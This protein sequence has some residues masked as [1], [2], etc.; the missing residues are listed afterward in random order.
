MY[1]ETPKISRAAAAP[2]NSATVFATFATSS[3]TIAKTVQRTPNRSRIRSDSPCPVTTPSRA[4]ISWTTAR[5]T[6]VIGKIQSSVSPVVGAHHAVGRDAAGV[7]A[8]DAGDEPGPMTARNASRPRRPRNRAAERPD[9]ATRAGD[10]ARPRSGAIGQEHGLADRQSRPGAAARRARASSPGRI[11]SIASSTVTMPDE[12]ALSVDDRHGEQVVA[13]DD[14]RDVVLVGVQPP[15]ATG[16]SIM[17]SAIG[18]S[19]RATIRSRSESTPT[20]CASSST[21]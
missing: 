17:T 4:A 20:R 15:T 19:G 11:V 21:T 8:G 5:I 2:E 9:G 12:L 6:I 14:T 1:R 16:S 3:T 18:V 13:G 10:R 7:V